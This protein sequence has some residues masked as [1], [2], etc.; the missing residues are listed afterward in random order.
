M[1]NS[2]LLSEVVAVSDELEV[3]VEPPVLQAARL[4]AAARVAATIVVN[5]LIL[6]LLI[7]FC[8]VR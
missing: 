2:V 1:V 4:R 8:V 6:L 5:F 3:V 7:S